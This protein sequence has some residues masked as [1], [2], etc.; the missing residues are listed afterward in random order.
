MRVI[1]WKGAPRHR[2][3]QDGDLEPWTAE[4]VAEFGENL[5]R[6]PA[7]HRQLFDLTLA[8]MMD[9]KYWLEWGDYS[10]YLTWQKA[11]DEGEVRNLV[12]GWLK[13]HSGNWY[14]VDQEPEL[15]NRQRIDIWLQN[16]SVASP[17]PI[18]IK[19]LDKGWSG[20]Q[21]CERLRNQ[22]VG[23][24][25]R[26][27]AGVRGLMLLVWQGIGSKK[28]WDIDGRMVRLEELRGAL[29]R[30]WDTISNSFPDVEA[31]EVV[32]IDLTLRGRLS[33][34]VNIE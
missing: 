2:A 6:T 16:Q 29:R 9:L 22:L 3:E 5:T 24:Y 21:L 19:V 11:G 14:T 28:S 33:S 23:D 18:E 34:K 25:M 4:Q 31:V 7:T 12:V 26:G 10:P 30:Y 1:R 15:A 32:L 13:D 8:R 27:T 20:P 17:V